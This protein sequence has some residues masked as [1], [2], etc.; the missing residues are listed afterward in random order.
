MRVSQQNRRDPST[1]ARNLVGDLLPAR[2]V[3]AGV[4]D[5]DAVRPV[6]PI[7]VDRAGVR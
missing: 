5:D 7:R 1:L 2:D 3:S 6:D 4:D